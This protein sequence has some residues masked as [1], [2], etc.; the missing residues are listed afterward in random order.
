MIKLSLST[1]V[2]CYNVPCIYSHTASAS[3][4]HSHT[5]VS[6]SHLTNKLLEC[7]P[8]L[9]LV[10]EETNL[11]P[12]SLPVP[13]VKDIELPLILGYYECHC[14]EHFPNVPCWID[15]KTLLG[16]ISEMECSGG[17]DIHIINFTG[18]YCPP[19]RKIHIFFIYL[20]TLN[21][22]NIQM[23]TEFLCVR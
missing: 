17:Q 1:E 12:F 2:T 13:L 8:F 4:S 21:V 16:C 14:D 18:H 9:S 6:L 20:L 5:D 15:M 19:G 7:K 23:S 3:F 10:L 22:S 11:R